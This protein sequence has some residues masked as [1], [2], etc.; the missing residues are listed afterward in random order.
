MRGF[1]PELT[2]MPRRMRIFGT[3]QYCSEEWAE[4]TFVWGMH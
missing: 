2:P 1:P 3:I 4:G